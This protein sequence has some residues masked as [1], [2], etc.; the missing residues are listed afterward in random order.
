MAD[1]RVRC[2]WRGFV[3]AGGGYS[4]PMC[5]V[6][7]V[8]NKSGPG[9]KQ[10]WPHEH[11]HGHRKRTHSRVKEIVQMLEEGCTDADLLKGVKS[12]SVLLEYP[13]LE[14]D[15]IKDIPLDYMHLVAGG[16]IKRFIENMFFPHVHRSTAKSYYR[17]QTNRYN[18]YLQSNSSLIVVSFQPSTKNK[19]SPLVLKTDSRDGQLNLQV[20]RLPQ[21]QHLLFSR[22]V[23]Y[24]EPEK[25][26][27][28]R[29]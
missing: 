8:R 18:C 21:S 26:F 15:V 19:S 16:V 7:A 1:A 22:C 12:K 10:I 28:A 2:L 11:S 23:C 24:S 17:S 29:V 3:G 6:K 20:R 13:E 27:T 25:E 9:G 4:C 14:L 5:E